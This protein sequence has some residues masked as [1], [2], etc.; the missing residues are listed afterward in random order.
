MEDK[1]LKDL[2]TFELVDIL[3]KGYIA[4]EGCSREEAVIGV[5]HT[6][7]KCLIEEIE[8]VGEMLEK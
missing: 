1:N 3:A 4:L 7:K 6:V 2:G 5:I 8:W